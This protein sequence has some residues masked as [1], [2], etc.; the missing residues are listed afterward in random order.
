MTD[1][2]IIFS[3]DG[4]IYTI[5]RITP[6]VRAASN[7]KE[8]TKGSER[9]M[10]ARTRTAI[11]LG[12]LVALTCSVTLLAQT[13]KPAAGKAT[14][15][16]TAIGKKDAA[17]P[18]V[19]KNDVQLTVNKERKQAAGW[20]KGNSLALAI[21]IDDDLDTSAA[22]QWNDLREFILAQPADTLVAVAYASNSTAMVAQDFTTDH[23][24]A[25]KALR[26]PRGQ[27]GGGSSPYL[28]VID[29]LKRWPD[30]GGRRS[31]LLISSGIDNFRGA[32]GPFYPDVDTVI[33][34]AQRENVNLWS[35][36]S[37]GFGHRSRS[38]ALSNLGQNNLSKM[39]DETGG[40]SFYLGTSAPVSFKPYLDEL[41]AHL[42][43]QY[44]L[45]FAGDGGSKGKYVRIQLK[46]EL[47]DAE[48][49][50]ANNAYINPLS[51]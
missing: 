16:V 17:P 8:A 1:W 42:G 22:S 6:D 18:S 34:R 12:S 49:S 40:E 39:T 37:P 38:F 41:E 43:N 26:I 27:L 51:N 47:R 32:W 19:S 35:I 5:P 3:D 48:F 44:L 50:H 24:L 33:S 9:I 46:T 23:A 31:L 21:L 25:A 4:E 11:L 13:P 29:W 14:I 30:K 45:T 28:A 10:N 15:T 7:H 2:P 36:Y 20:E